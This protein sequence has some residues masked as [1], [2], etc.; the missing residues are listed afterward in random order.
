MKAVLARRRGD[1]S[2]EGIASVVD[3]RL[4]PTGRPIVT[5]LGY[6]RRL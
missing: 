6:A 1:I 4:D 5:Y 3:F 2:D